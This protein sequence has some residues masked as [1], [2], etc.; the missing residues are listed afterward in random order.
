MANALAIFNCPVWCVADHIDDLAK[1]LNGLDPFEL[2]HT[3]GDARWDTGAT[4]ILI[5]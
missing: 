3:T 1:D 2:R 5:M 4:P